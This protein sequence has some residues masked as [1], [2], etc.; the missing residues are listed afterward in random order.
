MARTPEI[1]YIQLYIDG[2]GARKLSTWE[3][4]EKQPAPKAKPRPQKARVM[5][6]DPVAISGIVVAAVMMV[7]MAI[8]SLELIHT[9]NEYN[10]M[11]DYVH[12]LQ[13]TNEDLSLQY[14][15]GIDLADVEQKALALGM[16]PAEQV[17][18][19]TI[20]VAPVQPVEEPSFWDRVGTFLSGL[21][22]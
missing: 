13:Q 16:V 12:T 2:S 17:Q 3:L 6:I 20:Q 14:S 19:V 15:Q 11:L 21:F 7:L 1:Q 5:Y 4:P 8:G 10:E 18:Q 22:A 9:H